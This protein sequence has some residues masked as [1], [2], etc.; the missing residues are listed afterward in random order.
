MAGLSSNVMNMKFMQKA[1]DKYKPEDKQPEAKK[2]KDVSEWSL[3]RGAIK[4]NLKPAV[5]IKTVGYGSIASLTAKEEESDSDEA[6]KHE[7]I[8]SSEKLVCLVETRVPPV[9]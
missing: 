9:V 5:T 3:P 2:V 8:P 7:T 6:I 4:Q 1:Q